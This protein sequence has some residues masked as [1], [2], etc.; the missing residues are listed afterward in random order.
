M[1][2]N[3]HILI[4][5][6]DAFIRKY[7][8]NQLIKGGLYSIALLGSFF[9]LITLLESVAWFST[10]VR[11]LLFYSYL[12]FGLTILIRFVVIP[13]AQLNKFGKR[14]T[15]VM[16]ANI[17]GR[18]FSN[19]QDL[20]LN[21]LQLNELS[22]SE[23]EQRELILAGINQK[24][25][26][27]QP[28]P[29]ASAIDLRKNSRYMYYALPPIIIVT[30]LL[31]ISPAKI[32][33]PGTRL[34]NHS[35]I[36]E[37]PL[38]F[39]IAILNGNLTAIQHENYTLQIELSGAEIPNEV[40]L[41][42]NGSELKMEKESNTR[43]SYTFNKIQR[44]QYFSFL[45]A[46][47][48]TREYELIVHPRPTILNFA[49]Q[50]DYP[51]YTGMKNELLNNAG[52]ITVPIGT[53]VNWQF[54]TRDTR[55]LSLTVNEETRVLEVNKGSNT[56]NY[57]SRI[58]KATPYA[59]SLGN[60]YMRGADS[61]S[62]FINVIPDLYPIMQVE[63]YRDSA[64]DNRLYFKGLIK[65]DYGF[66]RLNYF[67]TVKNQKGESFQKQTNINIESLNTRQSFYHFVDL[68]DI[69]ALPGDEVVY[70]FE[71]WDNDGI[72]GSKSSRSQEMHYKLPTLDEINKSLERNRENIEDVLKKGMQEARSI[73][74]DVQDIRK[75]LMEKKNLNYQDKQQIQQLLDRQKALQ[76]QMEQIRDQN[77]KTNQR[78]SEYKQV[79]EQL[80]EKQQQLEKL[81]NE[82]MSDELKKMFEELQQMLDNMDKDKLSEVMEKIQMSTEDME[83]SIDRNLEL[84]KQ[85]QFDK[86]L[87]E[88]I[89]KLKALAEE[90][91][92]LS[93]ETAGS[94]KKDKEEL[95][96]KQEEINREFESIKENLK[97]LEKENQQ[98][99]EPN[100]LF[101]VP[102]EQ[103]QKTQE[104][105]NQSGENLK[106]GKMKQAAGKQGEASDDMQKMSDMLFEMQ[107]E[108]EEEAL[109]E[110]INTVRLILENLVRSSF[111]QESLIGT[112][113]YTPVNS[114]KY[115]EVAEKQ[116]NIQDNLKV[117]E[118]S[119]VALSKRQSMIEPFVTKEISAINSNITTTLE[120]LTAR[121]VSAAMGKQQFVM[122]SI[123][124][125]ALMLA[126]SLDQMQ[127]SMNQMKSG[128]S[129][130][131]CPMPGAGK[132]SMK[133]MKQLQ[134]KL[135]EQME[136]MKKSMQEG[137]KGEQGKSG[138]STM[139][140]Q[141]ARMAAEQEAL[142]RQLQQYREELVKDG[143]LNDNKL[144]Q[145]IKNMEQT[146]SDLVNKLLNES[147]M[148]RQQEILTR[149][150]ESEKA[151]MQREKEEKRESNEAKDIPRPDPATFFDS[152]GL[153]S[154]ETELL[155]TI[156]P[157]LKVY[158]R[159]KVNAYF[160]IIP[161]NP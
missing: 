44:N 133:S 35:A 110:D 129:G 89:E 55:E 12:A 147:T 111:D 114:P 84:F 158:Y 50:L 22:I 80:L 161:L 119:L 21:T 16:A 79:N 76:Q 95:I 85:L 47:Y 126:E 149:L 150:L 116:K 128:K 13:I 33:E 63:E 117:V 131:S 7:Y 123:N 17:I 143:I 75:N 146:E 23:P 19:V 127:Q 34:L 155:R 106:S 66:K 32:L 51:A 25:N 48:T 68:A 3:Y 38:P 6:L 46:G 18:H 60:E 101:K 140:E 24:A 31:L 130:K 11:T 43:F 29:F 118:D 109:G 102:R 78:E 42:A 5:K 134:Q 39:N 151:E 105:L 83:K 64:Y 14:I 108:M 96:K 27:L 94:D 152:I 59:I 125:L 40:F 61:M 1:N 41:T 72:N 139:S 145:M 148:R 15:H 82:L 100:K 57:E 113:S 142:R 107:Q 153:P 159:D 90:Q 91:K 136:A 104:S 97:E 92:R 81:F 36:Y 87:T 30:A 58:M 154:R 135:N 132:P 20:L 144:N 10:A 65:D 9:L 124:N 37:K 88:N 49:L 56:L 69:Q 98:L 71:V 137:K 160:T 77:N 70:Y 54:A 156:P 138:Q 86:K 157:A 2:N 115:P 28:I 99:E 67:I 45:A 121:S 74:K 120:L 62:F 112:L 4:D 103:Q 73:Q 141:L 122:T 52:D 93:E 53:R 8:V 26:L